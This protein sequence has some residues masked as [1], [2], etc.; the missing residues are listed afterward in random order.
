[1]NNHHNTTATPPD[2]ALFYTLAE[3]AYLLRVSPWTIKRLIDRREIES[4]KVGARRLV[5]KDSLLNYVKRVST[6]AADPHSGLG[7]RYA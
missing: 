3:S 7:G 6:P 5:P 2:N 4:T 1:M